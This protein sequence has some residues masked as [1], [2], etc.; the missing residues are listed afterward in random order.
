[1]SFVVESSSVHF[2][3]IHLL[4]EPCHLLTRLVE[5]FFQGLLAAEG[6][7]PGAGPDPHAVDGDAVEVDQILIPQDG[8][9]NGVSSPSS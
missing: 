3:G 4:V 6:G 2:T 9:R 7:G 1:V 8:A 5:V